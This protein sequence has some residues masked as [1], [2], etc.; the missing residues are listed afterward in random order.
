MKPDKKIKIYFGDL[1]HN[2]L[3][4]GSYMFPLNIGLIASYSKKIFGKAIEIK[5]FKYPDMLI[6][7]LED[8]SPVILGMSNYT[9]NAHLNSQISNIAKS[10]NH[11]TI[12]VWGGPN[13]NHTEKGYQEFFNKYS[14]V[15]FY[16]INEGEKGFVNL[17][18]ASPGSVRA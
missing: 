1:V 14:M 10:I 12:V 9:W 18:N 15:D 3:G 6:K 17:R 16:I 5:L 13:I 8:I 2:Y 4:G 11:Q 7:K